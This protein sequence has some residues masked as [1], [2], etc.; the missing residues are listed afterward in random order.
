M[1]AVHVPR[2]LLSRSGHSPRPDLLC[3]RSMQCRCVHFIPLDWEAALM[4]SRPSHHHEDLRPTDHRESPVC[5][6]PIIGHRQ[7]TRIQKSGLPRDPTT[8]AG[9]R[10]SVGWGYRLEIERGYEYP[11]G[12]CDEQSLGWA[13]VR[14]SYP[15][16][17]KLRKTKGVD[18]GDRWR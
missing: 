15:A 3:R 6:S 11:G 10:G 16:M 13:T 5:D 7:L 1:A 17:K 4:N 2:L 14:P 12:L 8:R 9:I 18:L